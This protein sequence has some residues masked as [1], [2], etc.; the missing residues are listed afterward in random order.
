MARVGTGKGKEL[1]ALEFRNFK[2]IQYFI[3]NKIAQ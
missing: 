1:S 3:Y 2:P